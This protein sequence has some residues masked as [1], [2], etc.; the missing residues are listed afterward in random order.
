MDTL[1]IV[2]RGEE[3][4]DRQHRRALTLNGELGWVSWKVLMDHQAR[5]PRL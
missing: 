4:A 2:R 5:L 1:G 3:I